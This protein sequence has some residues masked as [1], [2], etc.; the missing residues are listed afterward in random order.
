MQM[1]V[2]ILAF[3]AKLLSG[4]TTRWIDCQPDASQRVYFAN[5][6]SHLDVLVVWAS[7][8]P[9]LRSLTSFALARFR[10]EWLSG[11]SRRSGSTVIISILIEKIFLKLL[12][13]IHFE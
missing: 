2:P 7:L 5:H 12:I 4:A 10:I 11:L 13:Q 1:T 6:T 3:V 8:P 9:D